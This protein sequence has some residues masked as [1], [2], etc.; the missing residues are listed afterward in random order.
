MHVCFLSIAAKVA[1]DLVGVDRRQVV[2]E[3]RDA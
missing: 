2:E 3:G 1:D